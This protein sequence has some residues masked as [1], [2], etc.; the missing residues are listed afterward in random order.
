[1]K[2]AARYLLLGACLSLIA[3]VDGNGS[4]GRQAA[5]ALAVEEDGRLSLEVAGRRFE[6]AAGQVAVSI[7]VSSWTYRFQGSRGGIRALSISSMPEQTAPGSLE[8][9]HAGGIL[10]RYIARD[11]GVEQEFLLPGPYAGGDVLLTGSVQTDLVPEVAS[12]FEGIRFRRENSTALFYGA[13]KARDARGRAALLEER[14]SQGEITIVVPASFLAVAQF[15]VVV[16]PF[17]GYQNPLDQAVDLAQSPAAAT[18]GGTQA[19]VVWSTDATS[20]RSVRGRVVDTRGNTIFGPTSLVDEPYGS[21]GTAYTR[22]RA[23]WSSF[24]SEWVVAANGVADSGN[25]GIHYLIRFNTVADNGTKVWGTYV[26]AAFVL[27]EVDVACNSSGRC[28]VVWAADYHRIGVTDGITGWFYT[29][30]T[31]AVGSTFDIVPPNFVV[32]S[33]PRVASNGTDFYVVVNQE[34]TF[35]NG[36]SVTAAGNVTEID[37]SQ[38]GGGS[39]ANPRVSFNAAL[40][41]YLVVWDNGSQVKGSTLTGATPPVPSGGDALI[42]TD[43]VSPELTSQLYAGWSLAKFNSAFTAPTVGLVR[44]DLT[45]VFESYGLYAF[46]PVHSF[47]VARF[48]NG[49]SLVVYEEEIVAGSDNDIMAREFV[50]PAVDYADTNNNGSAAAFVWRPGTN[51]T[52]YFK[53][54]LT[55][56]STSS[57]QFGTTGDIPVRMDFNGD[58]VADLAVFRPSNG[59]WYIDT[60]RNGTVNSS[61]Q[62][63]AAGDIPVPGDYDGD[64]RTDLAVFRPSNGTWYIK[65][66]VSL[67][68]TSVQFGA[69]GDIPVPADYNGD[70]KTDLAVW[71][72]STG[73]WYVDTDRNG[74]VD[75]QA[76]FGTIGDIPVPGDYGPSTGVGY[77][78]G[79]EEFAVFRP[80]NG[81]W[82]VSRNR[83]GVVSL[84]IPFGASGDIPVGGLYGD[85]G[86]VNSPFAVFRPS[87]G[88]WYVDTNNNGTVDISSQFGASGDIPMQQ[89]SGQYRN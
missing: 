57:V 56:G 86:N 87:N 25:A 12:G 47:D 5:P 69:N 74:T 7:G 40:G 68:T 29:P 20:T 54:D 17:I 2:L 46:A 31:N 58:G 77:P 9:R 4:G 51:A 50:P 75:I 3:A 36:F 6:F 64:G 24:D 15:P 10:E 84:A 21:T 76:Q 67:A 79:R 45:A 83:N 38:S 89:P 80:S 72:P 60:D 19:L 55:A 65:Y 18:N 52:F 34:N 16:D 78:D 8:Y 32:H 28:L 88:T 43:S 61:F 11:R 26:A 63:G 33:Q 35:V 59:T 14:W 23:A 13:A 37:P 41:K 85:T 39:R 44:P 22:P 62:F 48:S 66:A 27:G 49:L 73:T 53:G 30:G 70:F 1:M 81:T 42:A 71:R 82:Y